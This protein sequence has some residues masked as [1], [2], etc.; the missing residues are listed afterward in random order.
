M[1]GNRRSR[2]IILYYNVYCVGTEGGDIW[3]SLPYSSRNRNLR[4]LYEMLVDLVC[5]LTYNLFSTGCKVVFCPA[6]SKLE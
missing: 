6:M 1:F 4:F 2:C 5:K 3:H